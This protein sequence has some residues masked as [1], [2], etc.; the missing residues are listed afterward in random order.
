LQAAGASIEAHSLLLEDYISVDVLAGADR[1]DCHLCGA[2]CSSGLML[3][4]RPAE[5][6]FWSAAM[7][8]SPPAQ[9]RVDPAGGLVPGEPVAI[10]TIDLTPL[11]PSGSAHFE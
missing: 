4:H 11:A 7:P 1:A 10:L 6:R 8:R 9:Q 5:Q 3:A 2:V